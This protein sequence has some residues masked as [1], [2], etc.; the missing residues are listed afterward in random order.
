M[1]ITTYD[2]I[3]KDPKS[4]V[5]FHIWTESTTEQHSH[6]YYEIFIVTN[7]VINHIYNNAEFTLFK[8]DLCLIRPNDVHRIMTIKKS[9]ACHVNIA[10]THSFL[11]QICAFFDSDIFRFV[12]NADSLYLKLNKEEFD[13][14]VNMVNTLTLL[15]QD[16]S[17]E[18]FIIKNMIISALTVLLTKCHNAKE[19][20]P[21]WLNDFLLKINEPA[22]FENPVN[23]L[24]KLSNYSQSMLSKCFKKY[25]NQSLVQYFTKLKI[26][27]AC[28]LLKSTN[29]STLEI[30]NRVG[31]SSLSHFNKVFKSHTNLSPIEYKNK[32]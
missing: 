14:F 18:V 28:N 11:N 21:Q 19:E 27:Y 32:M 22:L 9:R 7:G 26:N 29:Y 25:M 2:N 17:K 8:G 3:F 4:G 12:E 16:R 1:I 6:N 5:D 23:E 13:Y 20:L 15:E 31:F 30:S 10:F 24:Y